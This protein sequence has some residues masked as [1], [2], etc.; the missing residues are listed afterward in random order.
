MS[1]HWLHLSDI[2]FHRK[3]A[4]RDTRARDGLLDYLVDMFEHGEIARPD[5]VFCT[6]D[7]AFGETGPESLAQQYDSAKDFFARLLAVCGSKAVPLP[8]TRLF[9]VPGNHDISRTEVDEDAQAALVNL[10]KDSRNHMVRINARLE[11]KPTPFVNAMKRLA[12]YETFVKEFLPHQLDSEGRCHYAQV[13]EVEGIRLGIAGFNS[14]WSCAG[15]EDDRNLWLGVEW[16]FNRAQRELKE[17]QIRIGLMHH[18]VDW[19]NE[20]EREVAT[21]RIASD[22]D[23]WLHGHAHNAW[24]EALG[25]HVRIGAGA[26]GAGTA[27]EFG[28]NLVRLDLPGLHEVHLHQFRDGWTIQPIAGQAPRG[29]WSFSLPARIQTWVAARNAPQRTAP[30][31]EPIRAP[32]AVAAIEPPRAFTRAPVS[33]QMNDIKELGNLHKKMAT[34]MVNNILAAQTTYSLTMIT[35][36]PGTGKTSLLEHIRDIFRDLI[37]ANHNENRNITNSANPTRVEA[38]FLSNK[39]LLGNSL[40][41]LLNS[42]INE[43][44]IIKLTRTNGVEKIKIILIDDID[45]CFDENYEILLK[46]IYAADFSEKMIVIATA[47]NEAMPSKNSNENAA[48]SELGVFDLSSSQAIHLFS[49]SRIEPIWLEYFNIVESIFADGRIFAKDFDSEELEKI[50]KKLLAFAGPFPPVIKQIV[51]NFV[52][53]P[54]DRARLLAFQNKA[55]QM[56]LAEELCNKDLKYVYFA[57]LDWIYV[58]LPA[59]YKRADSMGDAATFYQMAHSYL[60]SACLVW[61]NKSGIKRDLWD[62]DINQMPILFQVAFDNWKLKRGLRIQ[63]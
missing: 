44:G 29:V 22:F 47:K 50:I 59:S 23:F 12:A 62:F 25:N 20:A 42:T 18:P 11:T 2:H 26:V 1:I 19:L 15:P 61:D 45:E 33:S 9:V 49:P 35:N 41:N 40:Q 30:A 51:G 36:A 34:R 38:E 16:Q 58:Q 24:V 37:D 8:R 28:V 4:W 63:A 14:A 27:D 31:P 7:I 48:D 56:Q 57:A 54:W 39:Q 52:I 60:V 10:A 3:D 17:S 6:G 5:L 55:E 46:R 32:V 13:L 21:R 53:E 43:K